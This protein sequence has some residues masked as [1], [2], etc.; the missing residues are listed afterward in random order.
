MLKIFSIWWSIRKWRSWSRWVIR[1]SWR[2]QPKA[3]GPASGLEKEG[4][5]WEEA[6]ELVGRKAEVSAPVTGSEDENC[7]AFW[8]A[9]NCAAVGL[10]G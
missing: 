3:F 9:G 5:T 1:L 2:L 8:G 4:G 10:A 7:E 6:T